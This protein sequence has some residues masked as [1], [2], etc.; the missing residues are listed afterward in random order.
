MS[1]NLTAFF[2]TGLGTPKKK[3]PFFFDVFSFFGKNLDGEYDLF[4]LPNFLDL[5]KIG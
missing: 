1:P 3:G 5:K 4:N 2:G